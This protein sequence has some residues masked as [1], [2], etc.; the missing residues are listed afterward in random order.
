MFRRSVQRDRNRAPGLHIKHLASDAV[1]WVKCAPRSTSKMTCC[2]RSRNS[3]AKGTR[4]LG[5]GQT[6]AQCPRTKVHSPKWLRARIPQRST[7]S[8]RRP[9][10]F[11][12]MGGGHD[13]GED[14]LVSLGRLGQPCRSTEGPGRFPFFGQL[15]C[16]LGLYQSNESVFMDGG[17]W[18]GQ[19]VRS[20]R[21]TNPS[22]A[23]WRWLVST[24]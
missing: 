23:K 1:F 7:P 4:P 22:W 10:C 3:P 21:Q 11:T 15:A 5:G 12:R 20:K 2:V 19:V 16:Q 17:D 13:P 18:A 9:R 8:A 24:R 14:A 6:A